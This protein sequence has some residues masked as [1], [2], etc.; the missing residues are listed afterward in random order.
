[1]SIE[2]DWGR[3]GFITIK[4]RA[5]ECVSFGPSPSDTATIILLHEGL[6]CVA[7]WRD[8]PQRLS[9][10]TGCGVFV[11]SRAG[12]GQSD[13]DSLPR[14]LD[15]MTRE[16]VDVLPHVIDA[17]SAKKVILVGHSDGASI[18]AIYAGSFNDPRLGAIALMAPHFFT[19]PMGLAEIERAKIVFETTN[20]P[21]KMGKYH[22]HPEHT[23][24]GWNDS[25]LHPDFATW[26]ITDVIDYIRVPCLLIQGEQD[27]YG[28]MAQ[29]DVVQDRSYAPVDRVNIPDCKHTPFAEQP[30]VTL[31]AIA[32]FVAHLDRFDPLGR[33]AR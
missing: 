26:D 33:N 25:W 29:L 2:H 3:D 20:L 19:E 4:G 17:I 24:R 8:F 7:L 30:Q 10:A 1:M 27:Q 14:P 12:Y 5:L 32:D 16:A 11:Y 23:F 13:L 22:R 21:A 31:D 15:Y 28:T 18:A 9:D 6:G